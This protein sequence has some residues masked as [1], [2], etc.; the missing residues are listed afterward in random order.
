MELPS[1]G[2]DA[3]RDAHRPEIHKRLI[4]S[5]TVAVTFAA[6]AR[7]YDT[8][9]AKLLVWWLSP[10]VGAAAFDAITRKRVHPVWLISLAVFG[11]A[12]LRVLVMESPAWLS[13]GRALL[14]PILS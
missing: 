14:A 5:A 12:F 1:P 10:V 4:I 8:E 2:D 13:I 3:A 9:L 11:I 7:T 6:A